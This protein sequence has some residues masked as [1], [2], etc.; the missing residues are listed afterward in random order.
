MIPKV[1]INL[2]VLWICSLTTMNRRNLLKMSSS[3]LVG[4]VGVSAF[5][6]TVAAGDADPRSDPQDGT[7]PD[8][9]VPVVGVDPKAG[10]NQNNEAPPGV[11]LDHNVGWTGV[12]T[13]GPLLDVFENTKDI[14]RI[15][16]ER[17][18]NPK[19]Y[20]GECEV[21]YVNPELK[22][23]PWHFYTPPKPPGTYEFSWRVEFLDDAGGV[24][25]GTVI[26]RSHPYEIHPD[27]DPTGGISSTGG[28]AGTADA[29]VE[30]TDG[31]VRPI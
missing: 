27:A 16:G 2:V 3:A 19:Q 10:P 7:L 11:W 28:T 18:E 1:F 15:D 30:T 26:E 12:T 23:L 20:W 6:G 13:C 21:N 9:D 17:I 4:A 24:P 25:E 5:S 29:D 14:F 8:E 22:N 31:P